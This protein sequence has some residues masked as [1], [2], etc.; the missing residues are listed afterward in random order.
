M[1]TVIISF[2]A[3]II[4]G[5]N[6]VNTT[7]VTPHKI[8]P[9]TD[10]SYI[11]TDKSAS[12]FNSQAPCKCSLPNVSSGDG[13]SCV[14]KNQQRV[15]SPQPLNSNGGLETS[16]NGGTGW[17]SCIGYIC[18]LGYTNING[19]CINSNTVKL[20]CSIIPNNAQTVHQI[21]NDGGLSYGQCIIDSCNSGF[22]LINNSCVVTNQSKNCIVQNGNGNQNSTNGGQSWSLCI[23]TS[24]NNGY[25]NI[26]NIC[27]L[28]NQ[29]RSCLIV[30]GLGEQSTVNGGQSWSN[31]N[32]KTCNTNFSNQNNQCINSY[33]TRACVTQPLNSNGGIE[34]T[35]NSGITWGQCT[36]YICNTDYSLQ[37][38]V[39]VFTK[40]VQNLKIQ[41]YVNNFLTNAQKRNITL[42]V[43]IKIDFDQS[44]SNTQIIG[45]CVY[46]VPRY[47]SINPA[48]WNRTDITNSE[49]EYAIYHELGHCILDRN[50]KTDLT[51][52]VDYPSAQV[53]VSMMY[54][55]IISSTIYKNNLQY[56]NDELFDQSISLGNVAL[57]YNG[58]NQFNYTYYAN[59]LTMPISIKTVTFSKINGE[60]VCANGETKL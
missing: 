50:H 15:C 48:W 18:N 20:T 31:C 38:S 47:I 56:Y 13:L 55:S 28:T 3:L 19:N 36:G 54:P 32:V 35:S 27:V 42:N 21:S 23:I 2:L 53:P 41:S 29:T 8:N 37:G 51:S 43:N 34:S 57:Y 11:C 52:F 40:E 7:F 49:R 45:A 9:G 30:N 22:S 4:I 59:A 14:P 60:I 46:S 1:K 25:S 10:N 24:C 39:C 26:G 16:N 17:V 33:Q 6:P 44:L 12:N 5:C 58:Q